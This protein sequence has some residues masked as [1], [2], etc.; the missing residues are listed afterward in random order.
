MTDRYAVFGNPVSHSRSPDI[1][2]AFAAQRG[3]D[4]SYERIEAPLDGFAESVGAFFQAGGKGANVTVPFKEQAHDLCDVLTE[5]ARQAGAVN[6]LWRE[7]G[8]CY[9][10]NT[11]G[12]GLV[13]DLC[14]NQGWELQG[15]RILILGAGGA[16]RG[17]LGPLLA[18]TPAALTIA[19]RTVARARNL[20]TLFQNTHCPVAAAGLEELSGDFDV[21]LNAISAGLQGEMPALPASLVHRD[22]VAY[23]MVYGRQPTPFMR[24]AGAAGAAGICDGLGMLVEQ[25]AEAFQ[26]WRGWRPDTRPVLNSLRS[27]S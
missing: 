14:D 3:E 17:V 10:D 6:T 19:N 2:H 25:A 27:A 11:D 22:T 20:V 8:K 13:T 9:G 26:V 23:D 4:L 18:R 7:Q 12:A 15:R 24:W 1:H 16:V 21:I 5:R